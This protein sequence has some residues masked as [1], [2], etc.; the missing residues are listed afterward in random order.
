MLYITQIS[1]QNSYRY[2]FIQLIQNI[3][4]MIK[5]RFH[6]PD[7]KPHF[8][9][10]KSRTGSLLTLTF[11]RTNTYLATD[12]FTHIRCCTLPPWPPP[13]HTFQQNTPVHHRLPSHQLLYAA[14]RI[15][16]ASVSFT[17]TWGR[18]EIRPFISHYHDLADA[19]IHSVAILTFDPDP[20]LV[21]HTHKGPHVTFIFLRMT[22]TAPCNLMRSAACAEPWG[23]V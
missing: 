4:N 22:H 1:G 2:T 18:W 15:N 3:T 19:V 5:N 14:K 10:E 21:L 11:Q 7:L 13:G 23:D 6:I 16:A 17:R 12:I 8:A 20:P 9:V